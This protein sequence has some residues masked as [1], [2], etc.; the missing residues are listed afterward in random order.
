MTF[1]SLLIALK[2]LR[3]E[4]ESRHVTVDALKFGVAEYPAELITSSR[5]RLGIKL[6]RSLLMGE[7]FI[8]G[9]TGSSNTA[10]NN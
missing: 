1:N 7:K 6:A 5:K 9:T 3:T 8:V 10:G 4:L 2:D